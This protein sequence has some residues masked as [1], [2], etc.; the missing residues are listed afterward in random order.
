M[1]Y[2]KIFLKLSG[3]ISTVK[4][5]NL[6]EGMAPLALNRLVVIAPLFPLPRCP[7]LAH[8]CLPLHAMR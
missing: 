6:N 8:R 3:I 5:I 1:K 7:R 2:D 4:A